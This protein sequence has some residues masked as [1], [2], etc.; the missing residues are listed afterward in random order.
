M[1]RMTQ[2]LL[3]ST[4]VTILSIIASLGVMAAAGVEISGMTL[5]MPVVCSLFCA[6]PASGFTFYQNDRLRRLNGELGAAHAALTAAHVELAQKASRDAMTGFLNRE[7]FF[8]ALDRTRRSSDRGVLL[9]VDADHFKRINDEYGHLTG[10]EALMLITSAIRNSVRDGDEIGRIGGEEF[11]VFL[12]GADLGDAAEVSE[13][14]RLE[15]EKLVFLPRDGRRHRL[16]VSIGGAMC[17]PDAGISDM[18]RDADSR[19]YAAKNSGRNRV[20][21]PDQSERRAA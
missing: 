5:W 16:T 18:M 3:K 1:R 17:W 13:R 14:L 7:N 9:I 12:K 10:D 20:V 21:M 8:A 15:V 6:M 11:A 2:I 4:I 19:L